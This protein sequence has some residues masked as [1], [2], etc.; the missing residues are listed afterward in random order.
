MKRRSILKLTA[1]FMCAVMLVGAVPLAA[2]ADGEEEPKKVWLTASVTS[3]K[4]RDIL[5]VDSTPPAD[6]RE[7]GTSPFGFKKGDQRTT[8]T[9]HE[10]AVVN[11]S[12]YNNTVVTAYDN[13]AMLEKGQDEDLYKRYSRG[14]QA[15]IPNKTDRVVSAAAFDPTHAS[16]NNYGAFA[17]ISHTA[18][19]GNYTM[20]LWVAEM[21]DGRDAYT[22][23][24][25][26]IDIGNVNWM[27]SEKYTTQCEYAQVISGD[28]LG[29]GYEDCIALV[30]EID[31][32]SGTVGA[33]DDRM[34]LLIFKYDASKNQIV[35]VNEINLL[36]EMDAV[37]SY[38][39]VT[40]PLYRIAAG[41]FDFDGTDEL[42][43]TR[44]AATF[45][46]HTSLF[47]TPTYL[48]VFDGFGGNAPE[49]ISFRMI[50]RV[51]TD[52]EKNDIMYNSSVAS[53]DINGDGRD[54]IIVAGYKATIET[55]TGDISSSNA[56]TVDVFTD[57]GEDLSTIYSVDL[58]M[59]E[60]IKSG[61][62]TDTKDHSQLRPVGLGAFYPDGID[63]PAKIFLAGDVY[64]V[65]LGMLKKEYTYERFTTAKESYIKDTC[66]MQ[67]TAGNFNDDPAGRESIAFI[68]ASYSVNDSK[69]WCVGLRFNFISANHNDDE[70]SEDYGKT[71][72]TDN[73]ARYSRQLYNDYGAADVCSYF[74]DHYG[75]M[76]F[77]PLACDVN[78]DAVK[79][80]YVGTDYIYADPE[81]KAVLQA[82]PYFGSLGDWNAFLANTS[83]S[84]TTSYATSDTTTNTWGMEIG[85]T[86]NE[87]ISMPIGPDITQ[88]MSMGYT[89]TDTSSFTTTY[90]TSYTDTFSAGPYDTVVIR[91]IPIEIYSYNIWDNEKGKWATDENG[92]L[93]EVRTTVRLKPI[94]YQ[95][96][97]ADY[98]SFAAEYNDRLKDNDDAEKLLFIVDSEAHKGAGGYVDVLPLDNIGNPAAYTV[99][100]PDAEII[101]SGYALSINGGKTAT[102]VT[103]G[104]AT[105]Y[106]EEWDEGVSTD[107][108]L[109]FGGNAL[110]VEISA[111]V[112][113]NFSESS[114][115]GHS[116]T[117]ES[118]Y[119]GYG[120]VSNLYPSPDDV[121]YYSKYGFNW[122]FA[123]W[124]R[125]L[126]TKREEIPV[127]A[128][129]L[130]NVKCPGQFPND[131]EAH[132][133]TKTHLVNV[134]WTEPKDL[135]YV[136]DTRT[137]YCIYR[138]EMGATH[139]GTPI[140]TVDKDTYI[141]SENYTLL[142]PGKTYLYYVGAV[143]NDGDYVAVSD[144]CSSIT[145]GSLALEY[146][147]TVGSGVTAD[148]FYIKS[149]AALPVRS[150]VG[151]KF[152]HSWSDLSGN[153]VTNF[154]PG[155]TLVPKFTETGMLHVF[156]QFKLVKD[157]I[158]TVSMRM[159]AAVDS[160]DAYG[161]IKWE[162][163]LNDPTMSS[164]AVR[165]TAS[166]YSG[167][168]E[169]GVVV[170]PEEKFEAF[171]STKYYKS[172]AKYFTNFDITGIPAERFSDGTVLYARVTVVTADGV[173]IPG[174]IYEIELAKYAESIF[175]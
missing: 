69:D 107:Y 138:K 51:S 53:G 151:T 148:S 143:Y 23:K 38:S 29:T 103:K 172:Y 131:I 114:G 163:S 1:L 118:S 125:K 133:D 167:A 129:I 156:K 64:G 174:D 110:F 98:N 150:R 67:V 39:T 155:I 21:D 65:E 72:Y 54:D 113:L 121:Q 48:G 87:K 47:G 9:K 61:Y 32:N 111:G 154:T 20:R 31:E 166:V 45:E 102:S 63:M 10:L 93:A 99:A 170:T 94:F 11:G 68:A 81:I 145:G 33:S 134:S 108:S 79:V 28:L 37:N 36:E 40:P 112:K 89:R 70:E 97:I 142:E 55:A 146:K 83:Y 27:S 24:R 30:C 14:N 86:V 124:K 168:T 120:E 90:T 18:G 128:Y 157:G 109:E 15:M 139:R 26:S 43:V 13:A 85:Y 96:S 130:S 34:P 42:A 46:S 115:G 74:D 77:V 44:A 82:S 19:S 84:V 3:D 6:Y 71:Y 161:S 25:T 91:R 162:F 92:E 105:T 127:Y 12:N 117:T 56:F 171:D 152:L 126:S 88:S 52:G 149:G 17:A 76:S 60:Y 169:N 165:T 119:S 144:E 8:V 4:A 22:P 116:E 66:V 75:A 50:N 158:G 73:S 122:V 164:P 49:R 78:D 95:L 123:T 80:R 58:N 132:L 159:L 101:G 100:P 137:A 173:S 140:A 35:L 141:F 2:S 136:K 135:P 7:D 153:N 41:D 62:A 106:G 16:K 5:D 57:N 147:V 175:R 59:N 160:L 104:T